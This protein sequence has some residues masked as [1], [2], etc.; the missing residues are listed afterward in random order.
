M[1]LLTVDDS[2]TVRQIIRGAAAVLEMELLEAEDGNE[3]FR[4][5][6]ETNGEIDVILLDWNMPGMNG[7]EVLQKV[8]QDD[9]YKKIPVMMVT[10]E[11]EKGNIV[12]AI[13]AGADHY[14]VKPFTM[15]EL[16]KKIMECLGKGAV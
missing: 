9:K 14:M 2:K 16:T 5:L 11:S 1:R 3:A 15:E 7:Y 12:R 13:Q 8:K 10:T 4:R 6:T